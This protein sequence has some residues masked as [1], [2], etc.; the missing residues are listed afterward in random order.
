MEE[1]KEVVVATLVEEKKENKVSI[2]WGLVGI[3][4]LIVTFVTAL[5]IFASCTG[6]I[7]R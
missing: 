5:F 2:N 6:I 1:K 3:F 4:C 7:L